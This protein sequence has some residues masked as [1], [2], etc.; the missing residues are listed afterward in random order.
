MM[1]RVMV[2]RL[3]VV[4]VM[5]RMMHRMMTNGMMHRPRVRR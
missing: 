1:D 2:N 4:V 5:Y 3:V